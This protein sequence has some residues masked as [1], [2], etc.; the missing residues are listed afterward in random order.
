VISDEIHLWLH[1]C[2]S[3]RA[4]QLSAEYDFKEADF[5]EF[6]SWLDYKTILHYSHFGYEKL[7]SKMLTKQTT[8][9]ARKIPL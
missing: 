4:S 1:W 7:A 6:F 9:Y 2:R 5:M 8:I 3:Q